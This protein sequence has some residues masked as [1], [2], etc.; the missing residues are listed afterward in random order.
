RL[1]DLNKDGV[2]TADEKVVLMNGVSQPNFHTY[3]V[4]FG[5][6]EQEGKTY[7]SG[8]RRSGRRTFISRF[9]RCRG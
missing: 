4:G 2:F 7:L 5:L 1:E 8:R 9:R 3:T 6:T